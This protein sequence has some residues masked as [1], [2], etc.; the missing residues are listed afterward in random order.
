MFQLWMEVDSSQKEDSDDGGRETVC[1]CILKGKERQ[2]PIPLSLLPFRGNDYEIIVYLAGKFDY[3]NLQV[4]VQHFVALNIRRHHC[5]AGWWERVSSVTPLQ[6]PAETLLDIFGHF[7]PYRRY[8]ELVQRNHHDNDVRVV[9]DPVK[10]LQ[11]LL[12][13]REQRVDAPTA[14][15]RALL[16]DCDS[17]RIVI[18]YQTGRFY[19]IFICVNG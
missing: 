5:W 16:V 4:A 1:C 18:A 17:T 15:H 14:V 7:R 10:A 12:P 2:R 6:P 11:K 3:P 9:V 8:A 13:R 19:Y